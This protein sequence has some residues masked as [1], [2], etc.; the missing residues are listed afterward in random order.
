MYKIEKI[1]SKYDYIISEIIKNVGLEFGAIGNGYGTADKEVNNMS[2]Y[3]HD[4]ER[5]QYLIALINEAVVGGC[6]IAKFVN[7]PNTCELKKLF[8]LKEAR[9]LGVGKDLTIKSI[10]YAKTVGYKQ[11][12]LE[13]TSHMTSAVKLYESIG[14]TH[15][16]KALQGT[17]HQSCDVWMLLK[18]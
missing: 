15:L 12:Y 9:G 13:T 1:T 5:A 8:L 10:N 2:M 3:Y 16:T 17:I 7:D 18:F 11:C 6:G 4:E 14:F